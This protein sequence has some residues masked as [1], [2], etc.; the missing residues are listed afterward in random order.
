MIERLKKILSREGGREDVR[1]PREEKADFMLRYRNMGVGRLSLRK[2]TWRFEYTDDF[3]RQTAVPPIVNF[4]RLDKHYESDTLWPFF[5]IRIPGLKQPAV[6]R[7]IKEKN[8][9]ERNEAQLL[10]HFGKTSIANPFIL[11]PE[12]EPPLP[13]TGS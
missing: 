11:I 9:D 7:E 13:A 8:L 2:G 5:V 3:R 4:P 10:K 6:Q 1:P 12:E